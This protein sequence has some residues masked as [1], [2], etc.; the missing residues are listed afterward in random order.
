MSSRDKK[1]HPD[2]APPEAVEAAAADETAI[3]PAAEA[4]T[5]VVSG[6]AADV[7]ATTQ[8]VSDEGSNI[9]DS[10]ASEGEPAKSKV[11]ASKGAKAPKEPKTMRIRL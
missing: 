4:T 3:A 7:T 1:E 8:A 2:V 10:A 6:D 9:S 11:K 5:A